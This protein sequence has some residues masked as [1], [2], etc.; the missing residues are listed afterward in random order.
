MRVWRL[1][2]IA[3]AVLALSG[4]TMNPPYWLRRPP[5]K[6]VGNASCMPPG[7]VLVV[8]RI[9]NP[10]RSVSLRVILIVALRVYAELSTLMVPL[11]VAQ[12]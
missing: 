12:L 1:A 5:Q 8:A 9:P 2:P 3:L 10:F 11:Q 6:I 7:R 4:C